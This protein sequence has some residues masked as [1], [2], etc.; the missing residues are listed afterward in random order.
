MP[1]NSVDVQIMCG[2]NNLVDFFQPSPDAHGVE[3][4][5]RRAQV[6]ESEEAEDARS[7]Q[8]SRLRHSHGKLKAV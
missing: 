1:I 6:G 4:V 8:N 3:V 5:A 2:V 7:R